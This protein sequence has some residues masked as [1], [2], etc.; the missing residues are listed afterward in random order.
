M[1]LATTQ[2][3]HVAEVA[4]RFDSGQSREEATSY[5]KRFQNWKTAKP[6][7]LYTDSQIEA[8]LTEAGYPPQVEAATEEALA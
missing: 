2:E 6:T 7:R 3:I 8:I 1:S 4:F 5:L